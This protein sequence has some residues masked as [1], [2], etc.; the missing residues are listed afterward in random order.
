MSKENSKETKD[1]VLDFIKFQAPYIICVIGVSSLL[2]TMSNGLRIAIL[3]LCSLS[4]SI[5]N[6]MIKND[7]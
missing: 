4:L 2:F 3:G 5:I 1:K 7:M 6:K